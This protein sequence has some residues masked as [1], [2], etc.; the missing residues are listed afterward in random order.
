MSGGYAV[1]YQG[2]SGPSLFGP[3]LFAPVQTPRSRA[4]IGRFSTIF[5]NPCFCA[6]GLLCFRT[7]VDRG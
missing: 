5:G 2:T 3:V 4:K 7:L 6:S 1:F